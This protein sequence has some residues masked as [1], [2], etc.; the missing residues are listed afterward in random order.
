[1]KLK[2]F[3]IIILCLFLNI[4]TQAQKKIF[5]RVYNSSNV[6][7]GKGNLL[8]GT[9]S[10]I[11]LMHGHQH[12][13]IPVK[14]IVVIKTRHSAGHAILV[15]TAAG[16]SIGILLYTAATVIKNSESSFNLALIGTPMPVAGIVSGG[17]VAVARHKVTLRIDGD[18]EK[19][20]ITKQILPGMK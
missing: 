12:I 9:D 17:I 14:E 7:I 20:K 15:G 10:T 8:P 18:V 3:V 16:M 2:G 19:W 4:N 1:M 5:I 13:S 11:E 6:K